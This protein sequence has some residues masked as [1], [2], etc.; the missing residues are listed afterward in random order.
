MA[1]RHYLHCL[2]S[3]CLQATKPTFRE[4]LSHQFELLDEAEKLLTDFRK[5][6][7]SGQDRDFRDMIDANRQALIALEN[8]RGFVLDRQWS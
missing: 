2:R 5:L 8:S 1:F 4:A 7:I 3:Q 6:G